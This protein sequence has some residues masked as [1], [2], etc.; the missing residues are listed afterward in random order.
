LTSA[1]SLTAASSL[2]AKG[3]YSQLAGSYHGDV[4]NGTDLDP[5]VTTFILEPSG[6]LF[7]EYVVDEENGE[8]HGRL[9]NIV[10]ED[11]RTITLQWTDK[12]GEGFAVMEFAQDYPS[13]T[14]QWTSK[15]DSRPQP[16]NGK[17]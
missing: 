14:G 6:H 12:C 8:Y 10:F 15:D 3:P 13:F 2:A 5:V 9:S 16:W 11:V 17:K 1:L 7:G 4:F